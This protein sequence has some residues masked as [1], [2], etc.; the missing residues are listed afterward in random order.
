MRMNIAEIVKA[1]LDALEEQKVDAIAA[2]LTEDAIIDIPLSNT[3][4]LSPWFVFE[5]RDRALGYIGTI[6]QNFGQ[7]K[8]LDRAVYVAEDGRT[9][10]V[11]T[12]G[13]LIQRVKNAGYRNKYVFKF[14]IRD[15][16]VSHVSEYANPV[17]FA[18]LM[19]IDLG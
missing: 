4:D 8:L 19:G 13:D 18:K 1:Y 17:T 10:F 12:T 5:G 16:R 15:G 14:T 9:V 2:L 3:G 6:F 7:V 11:E